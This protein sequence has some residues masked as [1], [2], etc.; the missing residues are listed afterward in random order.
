MKTKTN[1][2]TK[3]MFHLLARFILIGVV[4]YGFLSLCNWN[5]NPHEWT[6]FSR[7][8]LGVI[9]VI[10]IINELDEI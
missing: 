6:G 9:G 7:V 1:T 8:I 2:R 5:F 4:A 3:R 10:F